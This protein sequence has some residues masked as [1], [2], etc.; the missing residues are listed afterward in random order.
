[1]KTVWIDSATGNITATGTFASGYDGERIVILT[2]GTMR[3]YPATGTKYAQIAN[4]GT[5]ILFSGITDSSNRSGFITMSATGI[6][7]S[8]GIPT[9]T[10]TAGFNVTNGSINAF[11]PYVKLRVDGR[12]AAGDGGT[13]RVEFAQT[14]SS[15]TDISASIINYYARSTGS[16]AVLISPV[17]GV[18]FV[19][20]AGAIAVTEGD[21]TTHGPIVASAFNNPSSRRF[22]MKEDKI[23]FGSKR[24]KRAKDIV[25]VVDSKEWEY[26]HEQKGSR[27]AKPLV[28]GNPDA[29]WD[30]P[31]KE[32]P[33]H[34]GPMAED[35]AAVAPSLVRRH[36]TDS[37]MVYTDVRDLVGVVWKAVQELLGEVETMQSQIE[38]MQSQVRKAGESE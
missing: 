32:T 26:I 37:T 25:K 38:A 36:P 3:F 1:V 28:E 16:R 18:G 7:T 21:A 30:W 2:D 14:N 10:I 5:N 19:W 23:R 11:S 20:D 33:K 17:S 6:T 31:E 13:R 4:N 24:D 12:T 29:E 35:L 15:G 8:F 34:Y 22:K 27:P 9:G